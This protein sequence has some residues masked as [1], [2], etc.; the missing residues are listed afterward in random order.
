MVPIAHA[1]DGGGSIRIPASECGLVGLKPTRGRV[2]RGPTSNESWAGGSTDG[3]LTRSVRDA[4]A[5]LDAIS[6]TM[7]GEPYY[8]PALPGPL[9]AEVGREPAALRIGFLDHAAGDYYLDDPECRTAV[10]STAS[11]LESL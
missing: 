8:P 3:A 1:S 9:A 6:A 4:A 11:I 5:V 2:S 7:P 10:A